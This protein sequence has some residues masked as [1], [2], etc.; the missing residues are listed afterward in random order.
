MSTEDDAY[1]RG[2]IDGEIHQ[3]LSSHDQHFAAI[4]GQLARMAAA[5]T[6]MNIAVAQVITKQQAIIDTTKATQDVLALAADR[7]WSRW[8][9]IFTVIGVLAT[10][11]GVYIAWRTTTGK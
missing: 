8:Q 1:A 4:N 10:V 6:E 9:K 2:K 5:L 7:R 3:R 11:V